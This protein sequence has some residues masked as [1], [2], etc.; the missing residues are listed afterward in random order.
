MLIILI[1]IFNFKM[2]KRRE[3]KRKKKKIMALIGNNK[4]MKQT[5]IFSFTH[6]YLNL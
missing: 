1:I 4:S 3:R 6:V 2:I 5:I